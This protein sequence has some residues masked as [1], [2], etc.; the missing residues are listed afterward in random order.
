LIVVER[1]AGKSVKHDYYL[2]NAKDGTTYEEFARAPHLR[3]LWDRIV[4]RMASASPKKNVVWRMTKFKV[5]E[6]LL[7][8]V[9]IIM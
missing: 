9:G 2:S 8:G 3:I 5:A 4:W 1:P 7:E 6:L